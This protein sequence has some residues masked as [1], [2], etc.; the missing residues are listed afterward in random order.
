MHVNTVHT[1]ALAK[2]TKP[3]VVHPGKI[4]PGKL[5]FSLS[6]L[7]TYMRVNTIKKT[8]VIIQGGHLELFWLGTG[9]NRH[10]GGLGSTWLVS[11]FCMLQLDHETL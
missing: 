8:P 9:L 11:C 2:M 3:A 6:I 10:E 4:L 7:L 5:L 1:A